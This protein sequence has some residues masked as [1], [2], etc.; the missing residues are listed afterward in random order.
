[1]AI[2][3]VE[4]PRPPDEPEPMPPSPPTVPK[5]EEPEPA[6]TREETMSS[7][8]LVSRVALPRLARPP[9][10]LSLLLVA[11]ARVLP[12]PQRRR[13][14]FRTITA[15]E[16][17]GDQLVVPVGPRLAP[18]R[19][20][21]GRGRCV[22]RDAR[23]TMPR[24]RRQASRKGSWR[25]GRRT[26]GPQ[27]QRDTR[28]VSHVREPEIV[29]SEVGPVA[30][31]STAELDGSCQRPFEVVHM[32]VHTYPGLRRRCGRLGLLKPS[33]PSPARSTIQYRRPS[34]ESG[35]SNARWNPQPKRAAQ[36]PCVRSGSGDSISHQSTSCSATRVPPLH[37]DREF[38]TRRGDVTEPRGARRTAPRMSCPDRLEASDQGCR[39]R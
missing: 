33:D 5:P 31:A 29:G 18:G 22:A 3:Q 28:R 11:G 2:L 16:Q 20:V 35:S 25:T 1:M 6:G 14:S 21:L 12:V 23:G 26:V 9:L 4:T 37:A 32:N 10:R 19:V 38:A 27:P 36:K 8:P 7:N 17:V 34:S 30:F 39:P 15:F 13:P 24:E